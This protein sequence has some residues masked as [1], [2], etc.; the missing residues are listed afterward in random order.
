MNTYIHAYIHAYMRKYCVN[1]RIIKK[2][3]DSDSEIAHESTVAVHPYLHVAAYTHMHMD[4]SIY[5]YI[6]T[7][8]QYP[9]TFMKM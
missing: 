3:K 9:H 5:M 2:H 6:Y 7:Y 4:Q 8:T 1:L